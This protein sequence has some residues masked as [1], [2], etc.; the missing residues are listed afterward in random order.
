MQGYFWNLTT[1][2]KV[3]YAWHLLCDRAYLPLPG[4]RKFRVFFPRSLCRT[5]PLVGFQVLAPGYIW[6]WC[7]GSKP[8]IFR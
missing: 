3:R 6:T 4:G 5:A 7:P 2:A 8:S 1:R